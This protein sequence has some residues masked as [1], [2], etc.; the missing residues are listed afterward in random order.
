MEFL[1]N[2]TFVNTEKITYKNKE[3]KDVTF[4]KVRFLD[5]FD[6]IYIFNSDKLLNF[7]C[8]DNVECRFEIRQY[9][10][11]KNVINNIILKDVTNKQIK[12]NVD[13]LFGGK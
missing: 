7:K 6:K 2:L 11:E 8:G 9:E 3:D 5:T 10:K 1:V 13:K 12:N 4:Y